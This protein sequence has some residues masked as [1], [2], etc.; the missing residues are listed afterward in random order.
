[1][2]PLMMAVIV[3]AVYV[4]A[5]AAAI[6][7][8]QYIARKSLF[9]QP[10]ASAPAPIKDVVVQLGGQVDFDLPRWLIMTIP[11]SALQT[12]REHPAVKYLQQ[13]VSGPFVEPTSTA[14]TARHVSH[15]SSR[16][17]FAAMDERHVQVRRRRQYLGDRQ[18]HLHV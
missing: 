17:Q 4:E 1:M 15:E 16:Q 11:D 13:V 3:A 5:G 9:V 2:K 7:G 8:H 12:I 18:R 6:G 10:N 14:T